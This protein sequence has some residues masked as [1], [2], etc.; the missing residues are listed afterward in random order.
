MDIKSLIIGRWKVK[1]VFAH[2]GY[3]IEDIIWMLYDIGANGEIIDDAYMLMKKGNVNTGFTYTDG[4]SHKAI[5]VIGNASSGEEFINTTIHEIHHLAVAI[6]IGLG[7]DLEAET[8][9]YIAG[10]LAYDLAEYICNL[11]CRLI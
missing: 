8:P 3:D 1:F 4:K 6:A 5:V 7:V 10:D 9:A 11:G 2:D